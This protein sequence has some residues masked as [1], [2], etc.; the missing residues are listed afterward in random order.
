MYYE[1]ERV[2]DDFSNLFSRF[3]S[4][5]RSDLDGTSTAQFYRG[6]LLTTGAAVR[7]LPRFG[8]SY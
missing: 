5:Y 2:Y 7:S 4:I 6:D 3:Q 1:R 8:S